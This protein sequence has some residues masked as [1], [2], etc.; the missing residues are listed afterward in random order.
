[1]RGVDFLLLSTCQNQNCIFANMSDNGWSTC[2]GVIQDHI[3]MHETDVYIISTDY[4]SE[5]LV[6]W[7]IFTEDEDHSDLLVSFQITV[8]ATALQFQKAL[9]KNDEVRIQYAIDDERRL[10]N[11]EENNEVSSSFH[12]L[13]AIPIIHLLLSFSRSPRTIFSSMQSSP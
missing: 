7:G 5:E 9:L 12:R 13:A 6:S 3:K 10:N 1:M 8:P 2:F 11:V 4:L